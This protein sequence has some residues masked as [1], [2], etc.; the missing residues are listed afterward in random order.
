MPPR[1]GRWAARAVVAGH[2]CSAACRG[3]GRAI[4]ADLHSFF[5]RG[6]CVCWAGVR[7]VPRCR[8]VPPPCA[9]VPLWCAPYPLSAVCRAKRPL[10]TRGCF[11]RSTWSTRGTWRCRCLGTD[12]VPYLRSPSASAPSRCGALRHRG[13]SKHRAALAHPR[14]VCERGAGWGTTVIPGAGPSPSPVRCVELVPVVP[15]PPAHTLARAGR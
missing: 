9:T 3:G 13:S 8:C 15:P 5:V 11:W 2:G 12:V 10:A 1:P 6:V 4:H 14:R 7:R